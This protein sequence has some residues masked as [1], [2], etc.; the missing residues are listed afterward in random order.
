MLALGPPDHS[1]WDGYAEF[2][3]FLGHTDDYRKARQD[4]LQRFGNT[5]DAFIGERTG[6]SCLFLSPSDEELRRATDLIDLALKSES[7]QV[8]GY[9]RYFRFAKALAEYRSSRFENAAKHLDAETMRVLGPAPRLLLAMC[10]FRLGQSELAREN[11]AAATASFD[12]DLTKATN[13]DSW[14]YHL[15]RR[16]AESLL[17]PSPSTP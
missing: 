2:C 5:T 13:A 4:L 6:R 17:G 3:L 1:S 9:F 12:W 8:R 16:E 14:R 15:L 7:P 10:Q 11:Y